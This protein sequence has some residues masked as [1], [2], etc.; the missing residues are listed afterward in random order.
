MGA[1]SSRDKAEVT[2]E[3]VMMFGKYKGQSLERILYGD[4]GYIVWLW[5]KNVLN[6]PDDMLSDAM[7]A[8]QE[9]DEPWYRAFCDEEPF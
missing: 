5:E 1:I 6:I 4:P 3:H 2:P 7:I 8:E 9:Q